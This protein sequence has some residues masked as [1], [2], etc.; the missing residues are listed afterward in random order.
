MNT[1]SFQGIVYGKHIVGEIL[2]QDTNVY[3]NNL[4][5]SS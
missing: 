1:V 4:K 3:V 2:I 5:K